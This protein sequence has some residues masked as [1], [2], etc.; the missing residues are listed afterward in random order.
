MSHTTCKGVYRKHG[1]TP[2][3]KQQIRLAGCPEARCGRE[4]CFV[5]PAT[6]P[7]VE[8]ADLPSVLPSLIFVRY[9]LPS[10]SVALRAFPP[11]PS[12]ISS[13]LDL[14]S[15]LS[16]WGAGRRMR[17]KPLQIQRLPRTR[18]CHPLHLHSHA[19]CP[20]GN[21]PSQIF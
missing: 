3:P 21:S 14:T 4:I 11:L 20:C 7:L 8:A 17:A 10:F 19:F 2:M 6:L 16:F 13:F 5:I 9:F 18:T 15:F 1:L 12:F